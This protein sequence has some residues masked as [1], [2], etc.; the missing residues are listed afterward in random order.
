MVLGII[1]DTHGVLDPR[2]VA[3]LQEV[4]AIAHAGDVCAPIVLRELESIGAP[5]YAVA[6]NMDPDDWPGGDLPSLVRFT[7]AGVR[8]LV[9]HDLGRLGP[10]PDDV[11]VVICGHTHRPREEWHG[12][13]LV[14]NPGSATSPR[15]MPSPSIALLEV[16]SASFV[17]FRLVFLDEDG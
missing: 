9:I 14:L 16:E 11:D 6:G 15:S 10:I 1:S 5:V 4:D 7:L 3:A 17:S 12:R 8:F 13:V 2:A